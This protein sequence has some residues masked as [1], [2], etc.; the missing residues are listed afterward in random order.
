M[1]DHRIYYAENARAPQ[2]FWATF[3]GTKAQ[4]TAS[5][6]GLLGELRQGWPRTAVWLDGQ[7]LRPPTGT[8][9]RGVALQPSV[10]P[11]AASAPPNA[12]EDND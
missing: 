7:R 6:L 12:G 8:R 4:A 11:G 3:V 5:A 1:G 10:T 9:N 2:E